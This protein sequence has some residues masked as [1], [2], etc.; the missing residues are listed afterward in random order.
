MPPAISLPSIDFNTIVPEIIV[1]ILAIVLILGDLFLPRDRKGVLT[2]VSAV[3]YFL[4]L[5]ACFLYFVNPDMPFTSFSGM[6][7]LD[8]LGLWFRVL[9][10]LSAL[11]G[12]VFAAN[13]IEEKGM[14]LG[15]F[16]SVLALATLGIMVV[17]ASQDLTGI[18]V[19]IE[20][21]SIATYIMTGFA[22]NNRMSNE[23]ALKYFL[24]GTF[25]T[26]ILVYGM[27]WL[28]GMTGTTNIPLIATQVRTLVASGA[29]GQGGLLLATLL[30]VAG[31]GFKVA[32]VPFHMWTP[33][34]YQGAP[35]PVT[36]IMSVGPKAAGFA[37]IVRI[38]IEGLGP[39]WQQW[40]P[41]IAV[42]SVLTMTVGNVIALVQR[43]VKR[44]LAY[45]SIAHTGYILVAV[46]S[47]DP[48][49]VAGV[50]G[51]QAVAS[52]LFYLFAY[53]FMNMGAFGLVIWMERH[54]GTEFLNDYRGLSSWAPLPAATMLLLMLSLAGIPPTIGFL[55]KYYVFLAAINSNLVWLAV[56]G[57]LNSALATFYYLRVIWYMYFETPET[58]LT[59]RPATL[60]NTGLV[61][62]ALAT[63]VLFI[64]GGIFLGMT[65]LSTPLVIGNLLPALAGR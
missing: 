50:N 53:V 13:Y 49:K 8:K 52:I 1:A 31:L 9:A 58:T 47:Y 57:V 38:M 21:S 18:F 5:A 17:A 33:D 54:G 43:S 65:Q 41:V 59:A 29:A 63:V 28:Y 35:T 60:V 3:G 7:V 27:A 39:A 55:G 19:G 15:D 46:A 2:W 64:L 42:L 61:F 48:T 44:M 23:G 30:I 6:I 24:L 22:R 56:I 12:V 45:S 26:A 16:Y 62:T 11:I 51:N 14:P 36:A 34:A 40:V 32:A 37:A 20:L 10:I 4:A 25:A